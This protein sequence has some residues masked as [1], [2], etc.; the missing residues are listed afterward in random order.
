[1]KNYTLKKIG[2]GWKSKRNTLFNNR[3][4]LGDRTEAEVAGQVPPEV[5]PDQWKNFV[6]FRFSPE[7]VQRSGLVNSR[8]VSKMFVTPLAP[9]PFRW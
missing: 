7:G 2:D 1:M 4:K 8:A 9:V 5:D 6:K 3:N